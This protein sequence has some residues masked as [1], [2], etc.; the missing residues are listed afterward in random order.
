MQ[1]APL[2][3]QDPTINE[4]SKRITLRRLMKANSIEDQA[5]EEEVPKTPQQRLQSIENDQMKIGVFVPINPDDDD[6]QHLVEM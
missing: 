1:T 3:L 2:I 6:E 5:I 4:A